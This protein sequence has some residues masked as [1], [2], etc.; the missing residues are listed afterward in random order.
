MCGAGFQWR[1]LSSDRFGST[2]YTAERADNFDIYMPLWLARQNK[3]IFG[4]LFIGGEVVLVA[5]FLRAKS[6]IRTKL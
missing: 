6:A 1:T 4:A 3:T 5:S 2:I